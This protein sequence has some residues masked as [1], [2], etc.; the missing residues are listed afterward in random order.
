MKA[1]VLKKPTLID[2]FP[3][4]LSDVPEPD[5]G[6]GQVRILA[7]ACGVCR[8]DLH[9]VEG[10]LSLPKLPVV[11]GHQVVGVVDRLGKSTGKYRKGD[12]VG[13]SW[14]HWACGDCPNCKQGKENLCP[15]ARFTGY[16]VDGGYAQYLVAPEDF[17]YPIPN[18]FPDTQ[19]APLLC[20]GVIGYRSLRLSE[21][22]PGQTLGMYGFGGSAHVVIQVAIHWGCQVRVF[23][24]SKAHQKLARSLGAS[25][26]GTAEDGKADSLDSAIVFAPDG[27]LVPVAL[28]HVRRGGTVA[29][30]GIYMSPIPEMAYELLYGE[31][32]LR[33]VANSTR[34]D[35]QELLSLAAQIPIRTEVEVFPLSLA[36]Q[37]LKALK[38]S[39]ITGAAVL[40]IP[41]PGH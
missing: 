26:A 15:S 16:T 23:T 20:A 13:V 21:V 7:Q 29:L 10:E 35:V 31:R 32:T 6:Q 8:T 27:N 18:G 2:Q 40:E 38:D 17:V 19:A 12:R 39:K 4:V 28:E 22:Q 1:Q 24:R 36:N 5:P 33:S 11:P 37:A 3:L 25:W 14:L 34:Q 9:V 41:Q 30:A